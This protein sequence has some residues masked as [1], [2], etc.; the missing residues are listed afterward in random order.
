[1]N[2]WY[3]D[4]VWIKFCDLVK[5]LIEKFKRYNVELDLILIWEML[6]CWGSCILKGKIILNFEL[7]KVFK[8]C[9]EYVI[10]Y[11]FC[12]LVYY[13]YINKFFEL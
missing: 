5:F 1:M 7:I 13:Y 4:Y 2:D 6:I 12:Y 3:I 10:I 8:G 9:I 11:E